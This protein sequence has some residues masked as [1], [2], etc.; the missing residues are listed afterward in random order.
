MS[1]PLSFNWVNYVI[2]VYVGSTETLYNTLM[3]TGTTEGNEDE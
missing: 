2:A 3:W 1:F